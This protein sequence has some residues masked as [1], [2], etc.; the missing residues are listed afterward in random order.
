MGNSWA[1]KPSTSPATDSGKLQV[2]AINN[3]DDPSYKPIFSVGGD[4]VDAFNMLYGSVTDEEAKSL[5]EQ[6]LA[7]TY[8]GITPTSNSNV[9]RKFSRPIDVS[10]HKKFLFLLNNQGAVDDGARFFI[11]MG[12]ENNYHRAEI[13]LNTSNS[14]K[15]ITLEQTDLNKDGVPDA[16]FNGS[17]YTVYTSSAG[18]P[19][20]QAVPQIIMGITVKDGVSH[21]GMVYVNELH[22]AEPI[23]RVGNARKAEGSFEIPGWLSFGGKH[24]YVD[25]NF[26]TP[27]T[28]I[29]NQ[30]NEQQTGYL[31]ITRLAFLPMNFTAARQFLTTPNA[32]NTGANNLV[33]SLQEGKVK[34]FDGTAAGTFN[35][36]ALPRLGFNYT[37]NRSDYSL[38]ARTDEKDVYAGNLSYAV[39][40]NFFALPKNISLNYSLGRNQVSYNAVELTTTAAAGLFE[41]DERTD[42]YGGKLS[43][44]PWQGSSFNPGY[45]LSQVKEKRFSWPTDKMTITQIYAAD[46]D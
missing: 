8:S 2:L 3:I 42:I 35:V 28:A 21:S 5:S 13:P 6:T 20:F 23:I 32:S 44:I 46:R 45:S 25:R 18:T 12:D 41:T 4:A 38:L 40:L 33:K 37:K 39:P 22:V 11:Q 30:D 34:K 36:A 16:W 7:V 19:S 17:N 26:Q 14:W 24:R 9:Y 10:Q 27:V 43:F 15:L 1:V 29:T 31:N